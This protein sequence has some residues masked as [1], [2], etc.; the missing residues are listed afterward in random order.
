MIWQGDVTVLGICDGKLWLFKPYELEPDGLPFVVS[1]VTK[2]NDSTSFEFQ[3][4]LLTFVS[5]YKTFFYIQVLPYL[6]T[7]YVLN[8]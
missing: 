8:T 1:F 7:G 2:H 5:A 6:P 3:Y 4:Y